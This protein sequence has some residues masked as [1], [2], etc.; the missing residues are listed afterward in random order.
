MSEKNL[1]MEEKLE[2]IKLSDNNKNIT[3]EI[4]NNKIVNNQNHNQDKNTLEKGQFHTRKSK[5]EKINSE[6]EKYKVTLNFLN[7]LLKNMNKEEINDITQFKNIKRE[8]LLKESC[9]QILNEHINNIIQ[10]FGK[11][12]IRYNMRNKRNCY[13]LSVIKYLVSFC[14][15]NFVSNNISDYVIKNT[16]TY[17]YKSVVLYTIQ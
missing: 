4:T 7:G 13:V 9:N 16:M 14:G 10:Q 1:S 11:S 5:C 6:S 17:D 8:D 12:K 2:I 15:Y 3:K